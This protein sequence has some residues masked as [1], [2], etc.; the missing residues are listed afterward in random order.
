[1]PWHVEQ[2]DVRLHTSPSDGW[3]LSEVAVEGGLQVLLRQVVHIPPA[4]SV[5]LT[6]DKG[7]DEFIAFLLERTVDECRNLLLG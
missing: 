6:E 4:Q 7:S 1:M 3:S 2:A 5:G